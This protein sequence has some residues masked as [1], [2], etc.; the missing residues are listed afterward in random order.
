MRIVEAA[1]DVIDQ[2]LRIG[3]M[4]GRLLRAESRK[5][6]FDDLQIDRLRPRRLF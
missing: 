6:L 4:I 1:D 3:G 5:L 2:C